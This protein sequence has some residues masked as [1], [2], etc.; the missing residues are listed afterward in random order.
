MLGVSGIVMAG[1][2]SRRMGR[3]K[4]WVELAGKPLVQHVL[5]TIG[6]VCNEIIVVTNNPPG[7]EHLTRG[8]ARQSVRIISDAIPNAGSLGGI[9]SGLVTAHNEYSIAVACDMPFLNPALLSYMVRIAPGYDV[10]VP[11]VTVKRSVEGSRSSDAAR[12]T[13]RA[14]GSSHNSLCRA[15]DL[16]L[17]PLH[18]VYSKNC[19]LPIERGIARGDLRLICFYD[20]VSVRIVDENHVYE[21]DPQHLS[22]WNLNTPEELARAESSVT[23]GSMKE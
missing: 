22:F 20:E 5:D 6:L 10:V 11:S 21:F 2:L 3:D 14:Q 16:N 23:Q 12:G 15:K 18:A 1:G 7:Y 4:A 9:Y 13:E 17:H 8:T 19:I